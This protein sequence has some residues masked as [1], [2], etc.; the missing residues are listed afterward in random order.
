MYCNLEIVGRYDWWGEEY[1]V[2]GGIQVSDIF[3]LTDIFFED[4]LINFIEPRLRKL[5]E[6][7]GGD[8]SLPIQIAN[9]RRTVKFFIMRGTKQAW[10]WKAYIINWEE[11]YRL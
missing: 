10:W 2:G 9:D 3:K 5:Y 6:K 1:V 7:D 8:F 4:T 11:I